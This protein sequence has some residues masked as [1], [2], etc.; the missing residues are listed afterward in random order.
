MFYDRQKLGVTNFFLRQMKR[1]FIQTTIMLSL[2][3]YSV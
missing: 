1:K 3:K 2:L